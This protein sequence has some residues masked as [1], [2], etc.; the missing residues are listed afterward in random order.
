M[1]LNFRET[2]FVFMAISA[3]VMLSCCSIGG[4]KAVQ[5][6]LGDPFGTVGDSAFA[7]TPSSLDFGSLLINAT[8][9]K[10][11]QLANSSALSILVTDITLNSP[12]F[13][14]VSDTCP[15]AP[16]ELKSKQSCMAT[17]NFVPLAAGRQGAALQIKYGTADSSPGKFSSS[18]AA[19]GTGVSALNFAGIASIDNVTHKSM[20]L[21]WAA[22]SSVA[23]YLMFKIVSGTM[24]FENIV[25]NT[26]GTVTSSVISNLQ[27]S[28]SYT[29]RV[30]G[31]DAL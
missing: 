31:I 22:N 2:Y 1:R 29:W 21:N 8:S 26:S 15:R 17:L 9:T 23:S 30:R 3:I 14:L 18:F 25:V 4:S 7:S 28:T 20:H 5:A 10:T 6:A 27:P 13:T 19:S 11:I 12:H 16:V 24:V